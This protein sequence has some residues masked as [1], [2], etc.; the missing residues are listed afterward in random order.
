M[1]ISVIFFCYLSIPL[2]FSI[3]LPNLSFL[4]VMPTFY[5]DCFIC[6]S[7]KPTSTLLY[8]VWIS[9]YGTLF[10]ICKFCAFSVVAVN[11]SVLWYVTPCSLIDVCWC[12]R[13]ICPC[14]LFWWWKHQISLKHQYTS[15]MLHG[16]KWGGSKVFIIF[17]YTPLSESAIILKP[18]AFLDCVNVT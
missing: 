16:I 17:L 9:V 14:H 10:N 2:D 5:C 18:K 13:R 4:P 1:T 12:S 8:H 3:F 11:I 6:P 7:S 15:T